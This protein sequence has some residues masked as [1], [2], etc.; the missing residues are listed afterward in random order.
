MT[1]AGRR[2]FAET[3]RDQSTAGQVAAR[4]I[5]DAKDSIGTLHEQIVDIKRK[6]DASEAMVTEICRDIRTLDIAKGHL[7]ATINA[8]NHLRSL[9]EVVGELRTFADRRCVLRPIASD[10]LGKAPRRLALALS[11]GVLQR[12]PYI[13]RRR[14]HV[15][16]AV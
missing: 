12:R 4:D 13:R 3:V 14:L 1:A 15:C 5:A 6:A 10:A 11:Q 16:A 2:A 8:L 7:T 9:Q